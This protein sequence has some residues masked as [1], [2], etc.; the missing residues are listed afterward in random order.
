MVIIFS[1]SPPPPGIGWL[2]DERHQKEY[3]DRH[4]VHMIVGQY[5][6]KGFPWLVQPNLTDGN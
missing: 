4:G 2:R 1:P 3:I 5:M 6:G